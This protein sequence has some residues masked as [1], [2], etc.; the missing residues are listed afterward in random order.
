VIG[1][2][3]EKLGATTM[4]GENIAAGNDLAGL[5]VRTYFNR[6]DPGQRSQ[7]NASDITDDTSYPLSGNAFCAVAET[8]KL[9]NISTR[10]Q[11]G[12]GDNVLIGGFIITG[13][14]PKKVIL[15]GIGPSLQ[16]AGQPYPG[17]MADPTLELRDSNGALLIAND[18]W[19]NDPTSAAQLSAQGLAPQDLKEAGVFAPLPAGAF[20]AILAGKNG[21]TGLGLVEIYNLQ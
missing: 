19:Q 18:D 4:L 13:T 3:S 14:A 11:V 1:G 21:G 2:S 17:R 5:N 15:R 12:T 9:F 7:N 6:P 16:N 8:S 10:E 20:T